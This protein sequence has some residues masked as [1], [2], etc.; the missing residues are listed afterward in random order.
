MDFTLTLAITV[1]H[2][3]HHNEIFDSFHLFSNLLFGFD[4]LLYLLFPLFIFLSLVWILLLHS[5]HL[6]PL[7]IFLPLE[8]EVTFALHVMNISFV[9]LPNTMLSITVKREI[10]AELL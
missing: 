7:Y 10:P 9:K 6:F 1:Y 2:K 5:T 3:P 4:Y 8:V